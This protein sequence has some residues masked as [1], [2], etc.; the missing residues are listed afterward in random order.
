MPIPSVRGIAPAILLAFFLSF[1]HFAQAQIQGKWECS[2][3]SG[4]FDPNTHYNVRC[5]GTL[6]FKSDRVLESTC[7]DG[8][9]PS[10]TYWEVFDNRLTLRDSG[11][12]AF[13]DFEI[14]EISGEKLLLVRKGVQYAF[15]RIEKS[16]GAVS[17]S[18]Q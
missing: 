12:K 2:T 5:G 7:A 17:S 8:F 14:R 1:P 13:A 11:G 10:G 15:S 16:S 18:G 9:F 3:K 4:S 6:H